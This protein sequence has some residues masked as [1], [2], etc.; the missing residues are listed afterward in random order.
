MRAVVCRELTGMAGLALEAW[1]VPEPGPGEVRIRIAAAGVNFADTL[2]ISGTYQEKPNPPFVPGFEVAGT[3]DAL[4][5]DVRADLLGVR[6]LA[7]VAS[8]GYAEYALAASDD[9]VRLPPSID[10]VSAAGFA[11]AYGSSYGALRWE[12]RLQPGETLVVHGASGGV[13]LTAVECGKA[14]GAIV[15]ATCRGSEKGRIAREQGAD[16]VLDT[17]RDDLRAAIKELTDG[18]GA[19]V[20]FD[21][22]GKSVEQ[23]SL[24]GLAFGG[25]WL[26]VGFAGGGVPALPAN[27][28]MVKNIAVLG[29]NWGA[30][31]RRRPDLVRQGLGELLA[32]HAEGRLRPHVSHALPL[33]AY[34]EAMDLLRR[35]ASTGKVVLIT[36]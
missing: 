30:Y 25:R 4:G 27:I 12:A 1:P 11:I 29:F 17:D 34:A 6:V 22:V 24:R 18:R 14:M 20:V 16:H 7:T 3:V 32:W 15:I 21:P 23:A 10:D 28:L 13:G 26:I 35:R 9:L 8:G 2:V 19:D 36:G 31:R 5:P 33:D